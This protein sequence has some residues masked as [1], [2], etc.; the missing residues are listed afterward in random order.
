M[1]RTRALDVIKWRI[2]ENL[3]YKLNGREFW[4]YATCWLGHYGRLGTLSTWSEST[5]FLLILLS[6]V[7]CALMLHWA[8]N[9]SLHWTRWCLCVILFPLALR[10]RWDLSGPALCRRVFC[11]LHNPQPLHACKACA[12]SS[13]TMV[14]MMPHIDGIY[15]DC[16]LIGYGVL[17]QLLKELWRLSRL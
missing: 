7:K 12:F 10:T 14:V 8:A 4:R 5:L 2:E 17:P 3:Y 11:A 13:T 6:V 9:A 16:I 15:I 1:V